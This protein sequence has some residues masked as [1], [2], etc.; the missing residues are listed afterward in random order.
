M[1]TLPT[2]L[3]DLLRGLRSEGGFLVGRLALVVVIVAIIVV[4]ALIALIV[5]GG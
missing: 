5:P 4:A 3:R 2:H 1:T